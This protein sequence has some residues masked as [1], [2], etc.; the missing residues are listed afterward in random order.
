MDLRVLP[1][2][3]RGTPDGGAVVTGINLPAVHS[4][5]REPRPMRIDRPGP[6]RIVVAAYLLAYA[7]A[8]LLILGLAL[9]LPVGAPR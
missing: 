1:E 6:A 2:K 7:L 3:T 4:P 9:I 8:C 5:A